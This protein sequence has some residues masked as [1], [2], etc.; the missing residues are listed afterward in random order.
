MSDFLFTPLIGIVFAEKEGGLKMLDV[1]LKKAAAQLSKNMKGKVCVMD[2]SPADAPS[3][4]SEFGHV[5]SQGLTRHLLQQ[6]K[7]AYDVV[8][9]K[10]LTDIVRDAMVFGDDNATFDRLRKTASMDMLLSGNYS[11]GDGEILIELRAVDVQ[12]GR[13]EA[14]ASLHILRTESLDKMI[15]HRFKLYGEPDEKPETAGSMDILEV[16]AG[17]FYEGGDGKL[18]PVRD[19]MV[20]TSKDNYSIYICPRQTCHLYIYQV[21]SSQ[22]TFKLFPNPDLSEGTN[23]VKAGEEVWIPQKDFLFLDEQ[24]GTEEIYLFATKEPASGLENL[25]GSTLADVQKTIRTMGVGGHRGSE[26]VRKVK[27]TQSN[28]VELIQ[29]KLMSKNDFYY[30]L[31]FIHR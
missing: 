19:G 16:D 12:E 10:E 21:D 4:S 22:K 27:G 18:Y 20:L 2:F 5:A 8:A 23:P 6:K 30:R 28:P 15:S 9:R 3:Y 24:T 25:Q 29:K 11:V 26:V 14:S 17:V 7:R 1:S 13:V 31:T